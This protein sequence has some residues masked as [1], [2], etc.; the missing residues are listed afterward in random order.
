MI[1]QKDQMR[2]ANVKPGKSRS[3]DHLWLAGGCTHMNIHQNKRHGVA[4]AEAS[5]TRDEHVI[6]HIWSGEGT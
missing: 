4:R 1:K 3:L 6:A 5:A 2:N